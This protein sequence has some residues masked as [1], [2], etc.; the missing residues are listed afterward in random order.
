MRRTEGGSSTPKRKAKR[1]AQADVNKAAARVFKTPFDQ[2]KSRPATKATRQAATKAVRNVERTVAKPL[3][4]VSAPHEQAM[5]KFPKGTL[6][7]YPQVF[8]SPVAPGEKR[9]V[10]SEQRAQYLAASIAD[11]HKVLADARSARTSLSKKPAVDDRADLNL[12]PLHVS[13]KRADMK[14]WQKMDRTVHENAFGDAAGNQ[15]LVAHAE[16]DL[17]LAG[18]KQPGRWDHIKFWKPE[19]WGA[20]SGMPHKPETAAEWKAYAKSGVLP[21]SGFSGDD[22][23]SSGVV[24]GTLKKVGNDLL[25]VGTNAVP[26]LIHSGGVIGKSV[27][28]GDGKGAANEAYALTLKPFVDTAKDPK[29]AWN[30]HPGNVGLL[31]LGAKGAAGRGGGFV[32]RHT[33]IKAVKKA[34]SRDG[35][36]PLTHPSGNPEMNVG[37]VY[38]KDVITKGRQVLQDKA[39]VKRAEKAGRTP[40]TM[41]AKEVKRQVDEHASMARVQS[42]INQ[43]KVSKLAKQASGETVG[44]GAGRR[45]ASKAKAKVTGKKPEAPAR[46]GSTAALLLVQGIVDGTKADLQRYLNDV[47]VPAAKDLRG[48]ELKANEAARRNIEHDLK[49]YNEAQVRATAAA[50]STI[51]QHLEGQVAD[52]GVIKPSVAESTRLAPFAVLKGNAEAGTVARSA[53]VARIKQ[54]RRVAEK[55]AVDAL[56]AKRAGVDPVLLREQRRAGVTVS[57]IRI[58]GAKGQ[59]KPD[60]PAAVIAHDAARTKLLSSAKRELTTKVAAVVAAERGLAKARGRQEVMSRSVG[61]PRSGGQHGVNLAEAVL[62][63]AKAAVAPARAKVAAYERRVTQVGKTREKAAYDERLTA[64]RADEAKASAAVAENRAEKIAGHRDAVHNLRVTKAKTTAEGKA[65]LLEGGFPRK[66]GGVVSI[67]ELKLAMAKA[68]HTDPVYMTNKAAGAMSRKEPAAKRPTLSNEAAR[69]G[70][71]VLKGTLHTDAKTLIESPVARQD[72]IDRTNAYD[73]FVNHFQMYEKGEPKVF[74]TEKAAEAWARNHSGEHQYHP[75]SVLKGE[76]PLTESADVTWNVMHAAGGG[77]NR[78]VLVPSHALR[79]LEDHAKLQN[80][81]LTTAARLGAMWRRNVLM[82]SPPWLAGN[83]Q[84][85]LLR[86]V[87]GGVRP[88]DRKNAI[89]VLDELK[90]QDPAAYARFQART[91]GGGGQAGAVQRGSVQAHEM[92]DRH[93]FEQLRSSRKIGAGQAADAFNS[94]TNFVF[95][96]LNGRI[97]STLQTA[98]LGKILRDDPLFDHKLLRTSEQAVK[99]AAAGLRNTPAQVRMARQLS[100]MYGKYDKFSPSKRAMI[101]TYAPFAAWALSAVRFLTVVLPRDHPVLTGVL[102]ANNLATEDW[103]RLHGLIAHL[104]AEPGMKPGWLQGS[105]PG[106]DGSSLRASRFG[107]TGVVNSETGPLGVFGSLLVPQFSEAWQN[108]KG[109]DYKGSK[110]TGYGKPV[111]IERA[112]MAAL[113]SL[114][115]P[116]VPGAPKVVTLT[117]VRLPNMTD[118][119]Q[120][121]DKFWERFDR[122]FNPYR[123]VKPTK[124]S[125]SGMGGGGMGGGMSSSGM[126]GGL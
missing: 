102:S 39:A 61:G 115:V 30:E 78:F 21:V 45:A 121:D 3:K 14:A 123:W 113:T 23:K 41:T 48:E 91:V 66:G 55:Q 4:S 54:D 110:L 31:A 51:G 75:G 63:D 118:G 8:G 67:A 73:A 117:G 120:I 98:M 106:K 6:T 108:M 84:E 12:N 57:R 24:G 26:S 90:A 104:T 111:P 72:F 33:P 28:K 53:E 16:K 50:H 37:R 15:D 87:V 18:V 124:S 96:E 44:T 5:K 7:K 42:S 80:G 20:S 83:V 27:G 2:P 60:L 38:S 13:R 62:A 89:R 9:L 47:L 88:G 17:R 70:E 99:E 74:T 76:R 25:D 77:S 19:A 40:H 52:L 56:K 86:A 107:P 101:L 92:A 59:I 43:R 64:A 29:K 65:L 11:R 125:G 85:G 69:S 36:A 122:A 109:E 94:Y 68:G 10:K 103:R 58:K 22:I 79:Q 46:K 82:F 100:D 1:V 119:K 32:A 116:L 71:A 81:A 35:R 97:E 105:V 95:N 114:A 49:N 112:A 34:G 93:W 126:G